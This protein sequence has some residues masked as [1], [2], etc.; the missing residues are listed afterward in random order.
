MILSTL[1]VLFGRWSIPF[2]AQGHDRKWGK[3]LISRLFS[4]MI[5]MKEYM[6]V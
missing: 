3:M 5:D 2:H 1:R 6:I 4:A